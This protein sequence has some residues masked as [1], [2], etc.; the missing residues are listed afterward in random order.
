MEGMAAE[1]HVV[2]HTTT[3]GWTIP[4]AAGPVWFATLGEA[5]RAA[6]NQAGRNDTPVFLHDRYHRVRRLLAT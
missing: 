1:L 4:T 6:L 5:Q 2:P 3:G